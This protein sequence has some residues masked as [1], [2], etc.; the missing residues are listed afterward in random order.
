MRNPPPPMLPAL[1]QVTA[2]VNAVAMAASTALPPCLSISTPTS[3]AI[4][5]D[6]DT[7]PLLPRTGLLVAASSERQG[8]QQQYRAQGCDKELAKFDIVQRHHRC[9]WGQSL[10]SNDLGN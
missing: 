5:E 1:G 7:T 4:A 6:E 2:I 10:L 9:K 8:S 3:D